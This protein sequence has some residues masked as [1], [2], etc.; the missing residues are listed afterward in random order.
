MFLKK[1][2]IYMAFF[3]FN[4]QDQFIIDQQIDIL[5]RKY[6]KHRKS[7]LS[8]LEKERKI[9][10]YVL[11]AL[12]AYKY[13]PGEKLSNHPAA[14]VLQRMIGYLD[15]CGYTVK[16]NAKREYIAIVSSRNT[17]VMEEIEPVDVKPDCCM[18]LM[19][20]IK[21]TIQHGETLD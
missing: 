10:T 2:E 1:G 5:Q 19:S 6:D 12:I 21:Y 11:K 9:R 8:Q 4:I 14:F 3:N 16:S 18:S 20:A 17:Y 13:K 7:N 15:A